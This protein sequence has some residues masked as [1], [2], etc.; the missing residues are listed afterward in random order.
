MI[1]KPIIIGIGELLWDMLPTG[2][3]VGGA[4]VN[5]A[6]HA[7]RLGA[8]GYAVS[9]VGKDA[10]GDEIIQ[11]IDKVN[12]NPVIERV[13]YPTGTV[14]VELNEGIP[15][16]TINEGV[17]WDYIPL[18][19]AMKQLAKRADAVCF[20]TLA[21]RSEVSRNTIQALLSCVP[22]DSYRILD[23][24]IRQHYYSEKVITD[25]LRSSNVFKM[26]DE[27]LILLKK[28][29]KKQPFTDEEVCLWFLKEFNLKFLI[30]TAGANYSIIYTPEG[31]S[32]IKTPVVN[33]VDTVGAGDS[34]TGAFISS[35]LD[36]KSASDAHQTAVDRAAYVCSQAGAWV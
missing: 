14:G 6:Y 5:F 22:V 4:P 32:Y 23:I 24:N 16:Y 19:E 30:L 20:G 3:K 25:S 33:V 1:N 18:T 11:E 10:L 28:L 27:E 15:A 2:K 17:A 21:Q 13:N 12:I 8:A 34:F 35:I 26:N 36:G 31:L 29:F 7:S 9:A